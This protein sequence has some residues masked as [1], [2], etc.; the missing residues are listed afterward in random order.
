MALRGRGTL[1]V[2]ENSNPFFQT[3]AKHIGLDLAANR[4][5]DAPR[6][7]RPVPRDSNEGFDFSFMYEQ[8]STKIGVGVARSDSRISTMF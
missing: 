7:A 3:T 8:S 2:R 6:F 4:P 1:E 5:F